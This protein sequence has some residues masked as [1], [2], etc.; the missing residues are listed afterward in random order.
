MALKVS[1]D[2]TM[3]TTGMC[4]I[5]GVDIALSGCFDTA[6]STS[7]RYMRCPLSVRISTRA[8]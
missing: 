2:D 8:W 4:L 7:S 6:L 1:S 5:A 3:L